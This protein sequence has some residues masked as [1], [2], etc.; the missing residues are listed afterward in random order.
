MEKDSRK[1]DKQREKEKAGLYCC[2]HFVQIELRQKTA[3]LD[4]DLS[5]DVWVWLMFAQIL[6]KTD[7]KL[8]SQDITVF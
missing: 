2:A 5:C 6:I 3:L 1:T 7:I 4:C 8:N